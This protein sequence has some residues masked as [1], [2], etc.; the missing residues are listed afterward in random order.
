MATKLDTEKKLFVGPT[1]VREGTVVDAIRKA[2]ND[3]GGGPGGEGVSY[4][5]LEKHMIAN[6]APKKSQGYGPSYVKAYVRD[7]VNR[8]GHLSHTDDGHEYSS[9]AAPEPKPKAPKKLTKAQ[10]AEIEAL[11]FIRTK[12]EV[13]DAGDLDS[14][15]ITTQDFVT[16][17]GK[18][19]KTVDKMVDS[20]EGQGLVR[21]EQRED[22]TYVFLTQAG[23]ARLQEVDSQSTGEATSAT[24]SDGGE[25][26]G[27]E[28]GAEA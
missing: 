8:Y 15:Q 25:A 14:T 22:S 18:K 17:T 7:A 10:Q 11:N 4:A 19:A 21:K 27:A 26:A 1:A 28:A 20:L 2:V 24:G 5:D 6:W 23:L 16:E 3:L 13:S 9:I 12:G